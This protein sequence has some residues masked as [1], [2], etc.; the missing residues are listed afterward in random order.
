M[1][2]EL[3]SPEAAEETPV[4]EQVA[5]ALPA[6]QETPAPAAAT[7][8]AQPVHNPYLSRQAQELGV[9][10]DLIAAQTPDQLQQTV[11][12][13]TQQRMQLLQGSQQTAQSA[14]VEQPEAD[15][16]LSPEMRAELA[17]FDPR[18][19]KAIETAGRAGVERAKKAEAQLQEVKKHQ[20]QQAHVQQV[21]TAMDKIP[22]AHREAVLAKLAGM[23]RAGLLTPDMTPEM[24]VPLAH[25]ALLE[26]FGINSQPAQPA[27]PASPSPT[28]TAKP[29]NRLGSQ[30]VLSLRD[31]I[32]GDYRAKVEAW[33]AAEEAAASRNGKFVP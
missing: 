8:P 26:A 7:P 3:T 2:E 4:V 17:D 32:L 20:A 11:Y 27:K 13:L 10:P 23:E 15:F 28:P 9:P 5:D 24:A 12:L 31:E 16:A 21:R 33:D 6:P 29:S 30:P 1:A 18:I 22:A 14:P 25:K 19:L